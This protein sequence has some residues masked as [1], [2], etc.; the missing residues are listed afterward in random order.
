[1][2]FTNRLRK[3]D[4]FPTPKLLIQFSFGFAGCAL[5]I[6]LND[7]A[8]NASS[9]T[10]PTYASDF[11][12]HSRYNW[13]PLNEDT[14]PVIEV[15][16]GEIT[17]IQAVATKGELSYYVTSFKLEFS[18]DGSTWTYYQENGTDKVGF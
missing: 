3:N 16:M 17:Q 14:N 11:K 13:F 4:L 5:I 18:L 10:Q 6:H 15:N 2:V 1:M 8:F 7:S 9:S 12:F